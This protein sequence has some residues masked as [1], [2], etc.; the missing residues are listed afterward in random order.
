MERDGSEFFL[1]L[2]G[3][4]ISMLFIDLLLGRVPWM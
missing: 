4:A 2:L 1:I 3:I